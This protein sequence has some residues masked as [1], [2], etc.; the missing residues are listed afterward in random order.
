MWEYEHRAVTT[1]SRE[2]IWGLWADVPGWMAWNADLS[3]VEL[4]GEFGTGATIAMTTGTGDVIEVTV[5]EAVP[6]ERFVDVAELHG[7]TFRTVHSMATAADG[8]TE[9]TYRMEI[10]GDAADQVGPQVG[11][12]IVADWPET[13]AR[14]VKLAEG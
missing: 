6:N 12:D 4:R 8:R 13:V 1:A 3:A 7:L 10:T 14:L 9:I 5:A 11:P 2:R